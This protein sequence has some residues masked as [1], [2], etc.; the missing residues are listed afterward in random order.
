MLSLKIALQTRCLAQGLKQ[1]LLTAARLGYEGVQID[2]REELQPAELSATGLRQLRKMLNDLNL[3]VGSM[4]FPTRRGFASSEDL[5]RR[6]DATIAA[7]RMASRLG[8]GVLVVTPGPLPSADESMRSTLLDSLA[9][10]A[11]H[12]GRL[13]VLPALACPEAEP[14]E[15]A[16][17]ISALPEGL[18]GVDLNPADLIRQGQSPREFVGALGRRIVHVFAN[19]A[20]SG[21]GGGADDVELG[22]GLADF[23]ELLGAGGA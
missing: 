15:L 12:G 3:R 20:V 7:M 17:L 11:T 1:A 10:L 22:R 2:A 8:A 16:E 23:P 21:L 4:A 9:V 13:G 19:D 6:I 5:Q 18:A 14:A